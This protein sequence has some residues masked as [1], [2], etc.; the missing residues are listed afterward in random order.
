MALKRYPFLPSSESTVERDAMSLM[1]VPPSPALAYR[2]VSLMHSAWSSQCFLVLMP[3]YFFK[4]VNMS[5][6]N[7]L[8]RGGLSIR[9]QESAPA[10]SLFNHSH[11]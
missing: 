11:L 5:T 9:Q 6:S 7:S 10:H 1:S 4:E 3:L 8:L 2:I